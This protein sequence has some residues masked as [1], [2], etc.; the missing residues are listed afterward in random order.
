MVTDEHIVASQRIIYLNE[1]AKAARD[2]GDEALAK[3]LTRRRD[4]L[5]AK[6]EMQLFDNEKWALP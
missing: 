2:A 3:Q 4:T 6:Y 5:V 1:T